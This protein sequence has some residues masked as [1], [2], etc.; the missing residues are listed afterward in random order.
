MSDTYK[1]IATRA[2][3]LYKEK[4]SRFI[5]FAIPV[6]TEEEIKTHL[7]QLRKEYHDARH[8]CYAYRLGADGGVYRTNDDGE[9]SG[10]AGRPIYGRL[11]SADLTN[12]LV[13]VVRYFGGIKLGVSGL[14]NAYK[15]ATED[16]LANAVVET[17]IV[18]ARYE[19]HF[20]YAQMNAVMQLMKTKDIEIKTT[21]FN[22][23]CRI[24]F[25]VRQNDAEA[26]KQQLEKLNE[27]EVV[28]C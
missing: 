7:L 23:D 5:A 27:V 6:E 14:T 3:G 9:P 12:I 26:I 19:V 13:V 16:A 8:H 17:R 21:D 22:A 24:T 15:L 4:G 2:E 25:A 10:T 18:K 20:S 28:P 1:T 11:L